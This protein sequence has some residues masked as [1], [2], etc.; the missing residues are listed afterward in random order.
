M[1]KLYFFFLALGLSLFGCNRVVDN[2]PRFV[3]D[4]NLIT[5]D[6][7]GY[8]P[9]SRCDEYYYY[10]NIGEEYGNYIF[11]KCDFVYSFLFDEDGRIIQADYPG[12]RDTYEYA[13]TSCLFKSYYLK[14]LSATKDLSYNA[15]KG[16]LISPYESTPEYDSYGRIVEEILSEPSRHKCCIG[17]SF[18]LIK[19]SYANEEVTQSFFDSNDLLVLQYIANSDGY[20]DIQ[21]S[22]VKV[23]KTTKYDVKFNILSE[24]KVNSRKKIYKYEFDD[25]GNWI[26]LETYWDNTHI[27]SSVVLRTFEYFK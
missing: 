16:L 6:I 12:Q 9:I 8:G 19:Y 20:I 22:E 27:P 24:E 26:K 3:P 2:N 23:Y 18:I 11:G 15:D 10:D 13:D 1:K 5:Y 4:G 17:E 25:K 7:I 14:K 21:Y